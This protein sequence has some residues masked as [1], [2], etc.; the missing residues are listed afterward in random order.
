MR[1]LQHLLIPVPPMIEEAFGY[2]GSSRFV[3]FYWKPVRLGF[4]WADSAG[5]RISPHWAVWFAFAQHPRVYPFLE[6]F[7]LGS[8]GMGASHW[9]LLD[10]VK[11]A[12][13]IGLAFEVAAFLRSVPNETLSSDC[14]QFDSGDSAMIQ[15]ALCAI[16]G[17]WLD[18]EGS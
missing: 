13:S 4:S 16:V 18:E 7:N 5:T 10:R 6:S 3:A 8:D 12:F 11:R 9:L 17:E 1:D 2:T 14:E 15:S